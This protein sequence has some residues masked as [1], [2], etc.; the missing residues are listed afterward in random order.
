ME[1][2]CF[3]EMLVSTYESTLHHNP[4]E[5]CHHHQC[6]NLKF[7]LCVDQQKIVWMSLLHKPVLCNSFPVCMT[8]LNRHQSYKLIE[9]VMANMGI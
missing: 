7:L 6:K 9:D 8:C 1:T 5:Y 2:V 4:E 3:S